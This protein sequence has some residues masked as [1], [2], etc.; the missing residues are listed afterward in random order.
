MGGK[1]ANATACKPL[2]ESHSG[3]RVC[4]I[5]LRKMYSRF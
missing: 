1:V 2:L 4:Q 5:V 3:F